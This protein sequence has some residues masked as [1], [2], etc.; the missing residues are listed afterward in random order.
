MLRVSLRRV[1]EKPLFHQDFQQS[2]HA[3]FKGKDLDECR[4][5]WNIVLLVDF[6][7]VFF[8]YWLNLAAKRIIH[9]GLPRLS[10]ILRS[11]II[12]LHRIGQNESFRRNF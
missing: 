2:A 12:I 5:I 4:G 1:S 7:K 8:F 9:A 3:V 11:A 10:L 6:E